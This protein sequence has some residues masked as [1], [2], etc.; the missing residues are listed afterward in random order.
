M[1]STVPKDFVKYLQFY[2]W[3]NLTFRVTRICCSSSAFTMLFSTF[4]SLVGWENPHSLESTFY[5]EKSAE[6][7]A[8]NEEAKETRDSNLNELSEKSVWSIWNI[9]L[10]ITVFLLIALRKLFFFE[11]GN[12]RKFNKLLQFLIFYMINWFFAAE[13]IQR[14]KTIRRCKLQCKLLEEIRFIKT[15][16]II[17]IKEELILEFSQKKKY[18]K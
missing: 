12:Y 15:V 6:K 13:T 14:K 3:W 7:A 1:G 9:I 2:V 4:F 10:L 11:F 5:Y 17:P 18:R 16:M 8:K